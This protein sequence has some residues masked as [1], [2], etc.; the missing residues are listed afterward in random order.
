LIISWLPTF[1]DK[2]PSQVSIGG[3]DTLQNLGL[4]PP[5]EACPAPL[6]DLAT[7]KICPSPTNCHDIGYYPT[8]TVSQYRPSDILL[9]KEMKGLSS[10]VEFFR[11]AK[12]P[13]FRLMAGFNTQGSQ[14]WYWYSY[15]FCKAAQTVKYSTYHYSGDQLTPVLTALG[16]LTYCYQIPN[17]P[18]E[19]RMAYPLEALSIQ[20]IESVMYDPQFQ[21]GWKEYQSYNQRAYD[22]LRSAL[23]QLGEIIAQLTP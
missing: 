16:E 3:D 8:V 7:K 23:K 5:T 4:N 11:K 6:L 15:E 2:R 20:D 13:K 1:D 10:F 14:P 21:S 17:G 22:E 9:Y 19:Y 12:D 18:Y